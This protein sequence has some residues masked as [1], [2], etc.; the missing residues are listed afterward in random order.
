ML[1]W[2]R[3]PFKY[4][5]NPVWSKLRSTRE[6]SSGSKADFMS[7][8]IPALSIID[9]KM[10]SKAGYGLFKKKKKEQKESGDTKI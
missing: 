8:S 6:P 3:G 7:L 1:Q 10:A 5:E 2:G 4:P 9:L